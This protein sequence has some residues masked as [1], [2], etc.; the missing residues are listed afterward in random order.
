[1]DK[2]GYNYINLKLFTSANWKGIDKQDNND[3]K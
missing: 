1:M 3:T 2:Y